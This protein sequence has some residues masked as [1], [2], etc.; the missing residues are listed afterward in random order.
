MVK[1][2][3]S[4]SR[5]KVSINKVRRLRA[6][7]IARYRA[8]VDVYLDTDDHGIRVGDML[9]FAVFADW[10]VNTPESHWLTLKEIAWGTSLSKLKAAEALI[11]LASVLWSGFR[12]R[13]IGGVYHYALFEVWDK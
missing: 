13:S 8:S 1:K 5:Q 6:E 3:S 12:C 11:D 10:G 4:T 7:T 2:K 9:R